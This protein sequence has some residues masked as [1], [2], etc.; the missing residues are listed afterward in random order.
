MSK[1]IRL[2]AS[3]ISTHTYQN[4]PT[5]N[6]RARA[7]T[8]ARAHTHAHAH[9]HTDTHTH[10]SSS[11][12]WATSWYWRHPLHRGLRSIYW[13]ESNK[14]P[15]TQSEKRTAITE[16]N[17]LLMRGNTHL[18]SQKGFSTVPVCIRGGEPPLYSLQLSF[19]QHIASFTFPHFWFCLAFPTCILFYFTRLVPLNYEIITKRDL[20]KRDG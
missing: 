4:Y 9:T 7:R 19:T 15:P 5:Q 8:H 3:S 12:T 2:V 11:A 18:K 10:R 1:T 16:S 14:R 6:E 13:L 20:A 17:Q